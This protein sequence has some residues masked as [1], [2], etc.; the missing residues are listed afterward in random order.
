[1]L[2]YKKE[3]LIPMTF[4][5]ALEKKNDMFDLGNVVYKIGNL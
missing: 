5:K 3:D 1:M 2:L 4:W